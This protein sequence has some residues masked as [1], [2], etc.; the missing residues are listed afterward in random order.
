V[1]IR[2]GFGLLAGLF[3]GAHDSP[4]VIGDPGFEAPH[5]LAGGGALAELA[6]EVGV[7]GAARGSELDQGDERQGVVELAVTGARQPRSGVL[8]A[9]HLERR[10]AGVAGAVR[11]GGKRA[12]RP[13]R[14]SSRPAMTGPTPTVWADGWRGP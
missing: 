1:S 13:V 11:R 12:A 2:L 7:A 10:G 3:V 5:G 8:A 6:A 14:P 4:E 9:G